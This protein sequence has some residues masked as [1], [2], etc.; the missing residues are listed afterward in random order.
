MTTFAKGVTLGKKY[1]DKTHGFE[2]IATQHTR[3]LSGCDR[4]FLE[5]CNHQKA[6]LHGVWFDITEL[7]NVC[8]AKKDAKPGGPRME[9]PSRGAAK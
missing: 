1:R 8:V 7:E 9:Q 5:V 4:V 3:Y 2:G 6:E